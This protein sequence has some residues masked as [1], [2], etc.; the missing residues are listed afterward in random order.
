MSQNPDTKREQLE[1]LSKPE[2]IDLILQL[3]PRIQKLEDQVA[4]T[5][6]NSGKPPS[7]D[8]YKKGKPK[9]LRNHND[10]GSSRL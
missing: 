2:L 9:S 10:A 1:K 3:L 4:K 6:R 7:S 8:G 5:S